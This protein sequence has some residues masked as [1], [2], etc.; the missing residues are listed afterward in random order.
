MTEHKALNK[1]APPFR[2]RHICIG[3]RIHLLTFYGSS[4]YNVVLCNMAIANSSLHNLMSYTICRYLSLV[5]Y[6][7]VRTFVNFLS[8]RLLTHKCNENAQRKC[9]TFLCAKFNDSVVKVVGISNNLP[10]L[11]S[12]LY[13]NYQI[14]KTT[15]ITTT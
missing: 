15:K 4:T 2:Y 9:E 14:A 3:I 11:S 5:Y 13:I 10:L 7:I 6:C 8:S 1:N 12:P